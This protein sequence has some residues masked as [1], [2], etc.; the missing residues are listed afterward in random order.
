MKTRNLFY[1]LLAFAAISCAKEIA[2]EAVAP[3]QDINYVPKTFTAGIDATKTTMVNGFQIEWKAGDGVTVIDNVGKTAIKYTADAA[4]AVTTLSS[5]TGVAEGS[6]EFFAAYPWR[7][8]SPLTLQNEDELKNCYI[9]P[10]QR[11]GVGTYYVSCHYAMAKSDDKD[12]FTF[13]NVNSFIRFTLAQDLKDQVKAVYIFSNNDEEI[14]G[15]FIMKWNNGDPVAVYK[16]SSSK[17][18]FVRAYN[19]NG[20]VLKPG[21]YFLS[22]LPTVFEKGFTVVLQLM[23]GTQLMKRTDKKLTV[24]EGQ[25]LPMKALAKADYTADDFNYFVQYNEGFDMTFGGVVLN[26]TNEYF[27]ND[28]GANTYTIISKTS[29]TQSARGKNLF[30]VTPTAENA[31]ISGTPAEYA[32]VGMWK[33]QRSTVKQN[34]HMGYTEGGKL[35]LF[36]NLIV[37]PEGADVGFVRGAPQNFG[38]IV[39]SN[40]SFPALTRHFMDMHN[41]T[42]YDDSKLESI[43]IENSELCYVNCASEHCVL[44][45]SSKALALGSFTFVNN[46]VKSTGSTQ[47]WKF[48]NGYSTNTKTGVSMTDCK[49]TNNTIDVTSANS[50]VSVAGL[51]N[52]FYCNNNVLVV[53]LAKDAELLTVYQPGDTLIIPQSGECINNYFYSGN[54]FKFTKPSKYTGNLTRGGS[55]VKLTSSPLSSI[56]DPAK[57]K[58]G[59]YSFTVA[60]DLTAPAYNKVGAQRA[61]MVPSTAA[62]NSP[63]WD[64]SESELGTF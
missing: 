18:T 41:A 12:N 30:F 22:I 32:V 35:Y 28:K 34:G 23:D 49:V 7:E 37:N 42:T 40:C 15:E 61:D 39:V 1:A 4:G 47:V 10:D 58:F 54:D 8:N 16:S 46:V 57:G 62:L 56:W 5:A 3:E 38:K 9:T 50:F 11:P 44:M 64:Y 21:D 53:P 25:I 45:R 6:T 59:A 13:K 48:V 2:P 14:S 51:S 19:S 20:S 43:V 29:T 17:R 27:K 60:E 55:P 26:N 33:N 52:E 63:A 36:A 31:E 24:A